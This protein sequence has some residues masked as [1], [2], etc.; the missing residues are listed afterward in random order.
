MLG[1]CEE[2]NKRIRK[3]ALSFEILYFKYCPKNSLT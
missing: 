3:D 2:G 1:Q